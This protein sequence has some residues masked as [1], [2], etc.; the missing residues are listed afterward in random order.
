MSRRHVL[1]LGLVTALMLLIAAGAF[2]YLRSSGSGSGTA[3]AGAFTGPLDHFLVSAASTN[4]TAGAA[5]N[6]TITA[7]DSAGHTVTSY[8]GDRTLTFAGAAAIGSF[9]PTVTDKSGA[10]QPFGTAE[11]ITFASGVATV[12]GSNNGVLTL[13]K[14]ESPTIT[15]SD[16]THTGS[17]SVTVSDA[18][19]D[20]FLVGNPGTQIAGNSF[21]LG[22][23]AKDAY[24]N[25]ATSYTGTKCV[26]FSGPS[27]APKGTPPLYPAAGS[28]SAG[29]SSVAFSAGETSPFPSLTL[30]NA[31]TE[32][33]T[34]TDVGTGSHG[35]TPIQV[36]PA[37]LHSFSVANPG[38]QVAGVQFSLSVTALD[39]WQNVVTGWSG[40]TCEVFSGGT[41]SPNNT[42]P[43][44]PAQGACSPGQSSVTFSSGTASPNVTLFNG[45]T[46]NLTV[47]E[48]SSSS[49]GSTGSFTV[50]AGGLDSFTVSNPGTQ[51]AG[52]G[53]NVDLA[54][55]DHWG[56][57]AGGW[58]ST[59]GCVVFSGASNSPNSTA[60][61]YPAPG[62]SCSLGQSGLS[63]NAFGQA[64]AAITLYNAASTTL[65]IKDATTQTKSGST[66]F[67][68]N[69]GAPASVT[70]N[71]GDNQSATVNHAFAT[72]LKVAVKDGW[73]NTEPSGVSV[74]FTAPASGASGTFAASS[75]NTTTVSTASDG[76]ATASTFTANT[77]AGSYSVTATASGGSNPSASFSETNTADVANKLAFTQ[78]PASSTGGTAFPTQ[79]IVAVEDQYGNTVTTDSSQVTLA[80]T[81]GSGTSGATLSCD[82]SP[83][84]ASSGVASFAG[85]KI[86]KAGTGYTLTATDG[87]LSS[88][89]S[90]PF[91]VTVGPV[92]QLVFT[93]QPGGATVATAFTQQPVVTAEDAGGNTVTSY[94]GSITLSIKSGTG[95]SGATLTCTTNPKSAT[96]GVDSFAGCKIDKSGNGYQL[97]ATDGSLSVDSN[98][99]DVSQNVPLF[100]AIGTATT[101]GANPSAN[102]NVIVSYPGT[103]AVGDLLILVLCTNQE[104]GKPV[105]TT[106]TGWAAVADSGAI[107][108]KGAANSLHCQTFSHTAASGETSVTAV[109]AKGLVVSAGGEAWVID[110]HKP[111]GTITLAADTSSKNTASPITPTSVKVTTVPANEI[112]IV[113]NL[114]ATSLD[115]NSPGSPGGFTLEHTDTVTPSGGVT[116]TLG[117]ADSIVA[118]ANTTP[119]APVWDGVSAAWFGDVA[120]AS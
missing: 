97:H 47:T 107:G 118:T 38:A 92:S 28:C 66:T 100:Q 8:A 55:I 68:V 23:I 18:G 39:A 85:C 90:N 91:N 72:A 24:G 10:A 17:T 110:Y 101:F 83:L 104:Q 99:F 87:S 106:P 56:N 53:F 12:S 25:T 63:F 54:A 21:Q 32:T 75:S 15:V 11:Q 102:T 46:A 37:G 7:K 103:T 29:Q 1:R 42:A 78:S 59:T 43:V 16:G 96:A 13:Y 105:P 45:G 88:A 64:T 69:P 77:R 40:G 84:A 41:N 67:T 31:A 9:Q 74:T 117:V 14:A 73:G 20:S 19:I 115:F 82:S 22:I 70:K 57:A 71:A 35:S 6:L 5:D 48:P 36:N 80:I 113:V 94:A 3:D 93:T 2:G 27:N 95:T 119:T 112:E 52:T 81:S 120:P 116:V 109:V 114:T 49:T 86:D 65:T 98:A 76:T 61:S 58:T 26:T 51:T 89:T 108:T 62:I 34:V 4:P 30:Y 79:P 44:Y 111:N 60:P 33:L 50:N